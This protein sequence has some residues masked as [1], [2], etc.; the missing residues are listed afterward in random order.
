MAEQP[1][2]TVAPADATPAQALAGWEAIRYAVDH[3]LVA[4]LDK[5][6][7]LV[8]DARRVLARGR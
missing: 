2:P 7:T 3:S 1:P 5:A 6:Q 8:S 4:D